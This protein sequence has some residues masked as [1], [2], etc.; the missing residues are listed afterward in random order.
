[1]CARFSKDVQRISWLV[2]ERSCV[3]PS[4]LCPPGPSIRWLMCGASVSATTHSEQTLAYAQLRDESVGGAA[5][6]LVD[7]VRAAPV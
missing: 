1:M 4:P 6:R 5:R 3:R 7:I 2:V